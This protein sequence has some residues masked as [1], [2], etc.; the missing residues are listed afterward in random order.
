MKPTER[1]AMLKRFF[2]R[3][4]K[5]NPLDVKIEAIFAEMDLTAPD[6]EEYPKLLASLERL[7]K[8]KAE[9]RKDRISRDTLAIV[10]G[11]LL[12]ILLI[13]AYEHSHVITSR[14]Y[15]NVIRPRETGS[16]NT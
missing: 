6:S 9:E 11:N 5:P 16:K 13:V 10:I 3:G 15:N 12:G 7:K 4:D 1:E 2:R 14:A 8:I